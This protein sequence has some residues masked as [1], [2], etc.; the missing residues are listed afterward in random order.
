MKAISRRQQILYK[1]SDIHHRL[2][3]LGISACNNK[4]EY[5]TSAN[6]RLSE[7][8]KNIDSNADQLISEI[9][10]YKECLSYSHEEES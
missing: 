10:E 8:H 7:Y 1:I 6:W 9:E 2:M 3:Q 5:C 4:Y